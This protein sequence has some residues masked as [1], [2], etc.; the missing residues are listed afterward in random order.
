MA[1]GGAAGV[2]SLGFVK[3]QGFTRFAWVH[4][5]V[6]SRTLC[7]PQGSQAHGFKSWSQSEVRKGIRSG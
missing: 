3:C 5:A 1:V 6:G 4:G 7:G 2:L